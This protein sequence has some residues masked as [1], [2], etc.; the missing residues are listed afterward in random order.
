MAYFSR[1]QRCVLNPI[2]QQIVALLVQEKEMSIVDIVGRLS[3][4]RKE[5]YKVKRMAY[6][7]VNAHD[8]LVATGNVQYSGGVG[9]PSTFYKL[10]YQNLISD[11]SDIPVVKSPPSRIIRLTDTR[12]NANDGCK[13]M[14][15]FFSHDVDGFVVHI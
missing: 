10:N 11:T 9:K 3:N 6:L 2:A 4:D 12:H 15:G 1:L 5:A 7:L 14:H 8:I 13:S